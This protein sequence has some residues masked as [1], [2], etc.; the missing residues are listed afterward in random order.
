VSLQDRGDLITEALWL[1]GPEAY[2]R[3]NK[4]PG[5]SVEEL[6]SQ[7]FPNGGIYV[8]LDKGDYMVISC[9]PNGQG[10][11]SAVTP[12]MISSALNCAWMARTLLLT[13]VHIS[14]L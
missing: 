7:A 10:D 1:F 6:E 8:I 13:Q 14:T 3:R 9:C 11:V 2:E 4:L 5:R 12:T